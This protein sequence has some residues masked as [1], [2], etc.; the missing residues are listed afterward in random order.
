MMNDDGKMLIWRHDNL[1]P[2]DMPEA[3]IDFLRREGI[4]KQLG[5]V[6]IHNWRDAEQNRLPDLKDP[7][8]KACCL[9]TIAALDGV[10]ND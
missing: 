2:D 3:F 8:T 6:E 7:V 1:R 10:L 5:P 4:V 9:A